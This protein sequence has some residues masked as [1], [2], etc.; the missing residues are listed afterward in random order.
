MALLGVTADR[1]AA[2]TLQAPDL[3]LVRAQCVQSVETGAK[4]AQVLARQAG[5]VRFQDTL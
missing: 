1:R 5:T 3:H 2:Q 4:A